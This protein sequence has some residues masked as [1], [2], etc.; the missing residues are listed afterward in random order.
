VPLTLCLNRLSDFVKRHYVVRAGDDLYRPCV[1]PVAFSNSDSLTNDRLWHLVVQHGDTIEGSLVWERL[2]PTLRYVHQYGCRLARAQ[3]W[4]DQ[5]KGKLRS[6]RRI[7]C[8]AY[9]LSVDGVRGLPGTKGLSEI[10]SAD[11]VHKI[12]ANGELAHA[13]LIVKVNPV[14][15]NIEAT[16]TAIVDRLWHMSSGPFR[17]VCQGDEHIAA[18]PSTRL[19]EAPG[20]VQESVR[21]P[22]ARLWSLGRFQLDRLVWRTVRG[23]EAFASGR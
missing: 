8:G 4:D 2:A 18:H 1:Y 19:R 5:V 20:A 3:T 13:A 23:I 6:A 11:V 21:S 16:K 17:H 14:P 7:Y 12:E 9:E 10:Q 15:A 22:I